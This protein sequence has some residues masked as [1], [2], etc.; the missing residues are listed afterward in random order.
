[1]WKESSEGGKIATALA[2]I[3]LT[4]FWAAFLAGFCVKYF[5]LEA[6]HRILHL[7][8]GFRYACAH[9]YLLVASDLVTM[10]QGLKINQAP[11]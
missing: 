8:C 3:S 5:V 11:D 2:Y 1:M 7:V 4:W 9:S 10:N 6:K